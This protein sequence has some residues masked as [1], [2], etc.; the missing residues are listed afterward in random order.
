MLTSGRG[1]DI[2][3]TWSPDGSAIAYV[4]DQAGTPQI[5]IM[6]VNG[7][8]PRR[9]TL[10]GNYNTDPKW[11]PR[12]DL[13]AFTA[14]IEGRFQICTVRMDGTDWRVLTRSGSNQD[15]AWSPD[16]RMIAFQS[17]RDGKKLIYVMD[18]RGETQVPVSPVTGKAPAWSRTGR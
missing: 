1:N 12:G 10:Q 14:R 5:Y 2:S 11:S 8:E 7:G 17:N 3:P 9:L 18:A 16:G 4:S 15:P 13:L 6:P